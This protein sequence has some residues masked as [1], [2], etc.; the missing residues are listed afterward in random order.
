MNK[1]FEDLL[2]NTNLDLSLSVINR[3]N[4]SQLSVTSRIGAPRVFLGLLFGIPCLVLLFYGVR[5][6]GIYILLSLVFCPPL[7]ILSLLF[8]L[9]RQKKTFIPSHGVAIKSCS[10]LHIQRDMPVQ[11]PKNGV[12]QAYKRWSSGGE[13]GG[14]CYFY[15]VE[16][17]GLKGFGFCIAKNKK[18]RD[19]FATDLAK[20]LGYEVRDQDGQL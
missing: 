8:G 5:H 12:L 17:Q 13:S 10:L 6:Q 4:L 11:L 9:T 3:D 2:F 1:H 18:K 15:H 19:D 14:G 16:I 7:A 20:F